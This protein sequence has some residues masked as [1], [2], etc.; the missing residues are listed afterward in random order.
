MARRTKTRPL[1]TRYRPSPNKSSRH[2]ARITGIILHDTESHDYT[3]AKDV[4]GVL[5]WFAN[6]A[7]EVSAHY[8]ID[9]DGHVGRSVGD[10]D[11]AWHAANANP[12]TVGIE[13]VGFASLPRWKWLKRDRQLRKVAQFLAFYSLEYGIPLAKLGHVQGDRVYGVVRHSDLGV[14]GGGHHDPGDGY[15]LTRVLRYARWYRKHG[16]LP[17]R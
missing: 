7:S 15:P 1:S 3:G 17:S 6:P 8:V 4:E 13:Q 11:K 16:W 12:T 5:S 10:Y 14:W 9:A 2:G